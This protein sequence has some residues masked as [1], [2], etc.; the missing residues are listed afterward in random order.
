[1]LCMSG[2][3]PVCGP[4]AGTAAADAL[5]VR[6]MRP[7]TGWFRSAAGRP[8]GAGGRV[9]STTG[10]ASAA[11]RARSAS[12]R[13]A[14]AAAPASSRSASG[15]ARASA[16][17]NAA[18][19]P[20]P[21]RRRR[22]GPPRRPATI[23]S[24]G[25]P[26]AASARPSTRRPAVAGGTARSRSHCSLSGQTPRCT[27]VVSAR[28]TARG[29]ARARG[30]DA[31]GESKEPKP[32]RWPSRASTSRTTWP[33]SSTSR[34]RSG[35]RFLASQMQEG[36]PRHADPLNT[37]PT[38]AELYRTMWDNPKQVADMTIEFWAAQQQLWQNSM[39]KWLGAKDA[40]EDLQLPHMMKA[41]KRFAHKEW[42][43]NALF[44]YLKQ[45]YL[46]TSR[47]D[48][49]HASAPSARWTR[50]SAEGRLLHPLLRRGDEP[51]QLLRAE[52][53]GAR[54]DR[55]P[56]GRE[57]GARPED[58]A[59]ADLERG[60]GKLLIRQTDMDAFEVGRNTAVSPGRGG[61]RRTTS[62]SSSSTRR[63]PRRSTPSRC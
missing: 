25:A 58:D 56:E 3:L 26:Q 4:P 18:V 57:P 46:L 61:L 8:R 32:R 37:W 15:A 52:P 27:A 54:G 33:R 12:A 45:S 16:A 24:R 31:M 11:A 19:S 38:F 29:K 48:P 59:R 23:A 50:R 28:S 30:G 13:A 17:S 60:K 55:R 49:G 43:E 6:T 7:S 14:S 34:A 9:G 40:V 10:A 42:S 36:A 22:R 5:C 53:R 44:E 62:C 41:D 1:M 21:R 63:R 2:L 35:R 51:G 20:E 39:L 47:L